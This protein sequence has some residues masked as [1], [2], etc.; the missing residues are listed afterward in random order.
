LSYARSGRAKTRPP[1]G[2]RT[3]SRPVCGPI[4]VP[5]PLATA[6][7]GP[8]EDQSGSVTGPGQREGQGAIAAQ[9]AITMAY[10]YPPTLIAGPAVFVAV[11]I[12]VTVPEAEPTT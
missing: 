11:S 2:Q 10:G 8:Q 3:V 9:G 4:G 6:R 1:P 7:R 5:R 12:G